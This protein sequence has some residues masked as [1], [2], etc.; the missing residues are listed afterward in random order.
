MMIQNILA[1]LGLSEKEAKVYVT[2]LE[3]GPASVR[4]IAQAA[5]V[6]RGTTY[7]IIRSLQQ[8]GLAAY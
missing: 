5:G 2:C 8:R 7:D 3:I 4:S 6:N 1:K